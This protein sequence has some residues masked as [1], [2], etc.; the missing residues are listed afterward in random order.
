VVN[1]IATNI[2]TITIIKVWQTFVQFVPGIR[3]QYTS[4]T[5][6][7]VARNPKITESEPMA[8]FELHRAPKIF[9]PMHTKA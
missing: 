5:L 2:N 4:I 1:N 9:E 3:S 6:N 8:Y 7:K